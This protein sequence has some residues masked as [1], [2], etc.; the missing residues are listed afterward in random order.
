MLLGHR[1]KTSSLF[2]IAVRREF[3][4]ARLLCRVDQL[5]RP[6]AVNWY[7]ENTIKFV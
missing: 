2:W 3:T 1:S 6:E 4:M 7:I 5:T